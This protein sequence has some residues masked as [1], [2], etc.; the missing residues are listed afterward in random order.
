MISYGLVDIELLNMFVHADLIR[1]I[2]VLLNDILT[3]I[4]FKNESVCDVSCGYYLLN[5][6][7]NSLVRRIMFGYLF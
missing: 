7:I 3:M 1:C 5:S 2:L 6:S 4:T